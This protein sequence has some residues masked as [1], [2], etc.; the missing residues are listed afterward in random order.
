MPVLLPG[1]TAPPPVSQD[2][3]LKAHTDNWFACM[4]S[5]KLP[6]GNIETGFAHSVA[7]VMATRSYREGRRFY[8]DRKRELIV[9]TPPVA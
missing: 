6:N 3:D 4:R 9:D 5:R 7:V 1:E 2:D 8:W